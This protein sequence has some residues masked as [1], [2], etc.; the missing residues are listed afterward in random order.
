MV[1]KLLDAGIEKG[2]MMISTRVQGNYFFFVSS[3]SVFTAAIL[4]FISI[5]R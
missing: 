4:S 1:F 5:T 2:C 3:Y